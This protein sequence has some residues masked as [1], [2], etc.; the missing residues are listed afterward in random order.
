VSACFPAILLA[1]VIAPIAIFS[2]EP[3]RI[4]YDERPPY[5]SSDGMGG[6]RG[7]TADII[8]YAMKKTDI[9][10]RWELIP[11]PRQLMM[12]K[13]GNDR[14]AAL[15]WFRNPEREQFAKYSIPVYRDRSIAILTRKNHPAMLRHATL[16][17]LFGDG[18]RVLLVK[19]GYSYGPF[20]D[21]KIAEQKPMLMS[22]T[23][24]NREMITMIIRSRADYMFIAPEEA[25]PA[26]RAAGF[27]V[28]DFSLLNPSGMPSGEKR[29]LLFSRQVDDATIRRINRYIEEYHR[30]HGTQ[31]D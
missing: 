20:I 31:L 16:D 18:E 26:I 6:V 14:I 25:G 13:T 30:Q 29:Y 3:I 8:T 15:G 4:L 23:G 10:Y 12:I 9:P 21:R 27:S 17:S 1:I 28:A 2:A 7:L 11:S 22:V 5:M 19:A 24:G